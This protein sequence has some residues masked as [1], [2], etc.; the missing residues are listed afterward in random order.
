MNRLGF[1]IG[2]KFGIYQ[3]IGGIYALNSVEF[4]TNV[5]SDGATC[6]VSQ[7]S[8]KVFDLAVNLLSLNKKELTDILTTRSIQPIGQNQNV[9]V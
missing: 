3:I 1:D 9:I 5:T 7:S 4:Q 8:E 6:M 2:V